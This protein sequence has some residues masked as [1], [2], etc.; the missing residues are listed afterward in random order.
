MSTPTSENIAYL[1]YGKISV[2]SVTQT[3]TELEVVVPAESLPADGSLVY[4]SGNANIDDGF[5]TVSGIVDDSTFTIDNTDGSGTVAGGYM[6]FALQVSTYSGDDEDIQIIGKRKVRIDKVIRENIL[7]YKTVISIQTEPLTDAQ[8]TFLYSFVISDYQMCSIF[9]VDYTDVILQDRQIALDLID[10]Y[11]QAVGVPL[12]MIDRNVRFANP[13][14]YTVDSDSVGYY[15]GSPNGC[16]VKLTMNWTGTEVSRNFTVNLAQPY[17]VSIEAEEWD[18]VDDSQG[19][20]T[21]GFRPSCFIE[22]GTFGFNTEAGLQDD[23]LWLKNFCLAPSKRITVYG[24]YEMQVSNDFDSLNFSYIGGYLFNRT[25]SLNFIGTSI[26]QSQVSN[27]N[28]FTLDD[29]TLGLL[30]SDARLG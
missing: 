1:G 13:S 8:K 11:F 22:F 28:I 5:Y 30:D 7:G 6:W 9:N 21:H 15:S 26:Q 18:N 4:I 12:T 23:I 24:I 2:V 10:G 17:K 14:A 20:E 29:D 3:G 27:S 19:K 16:R 25:I